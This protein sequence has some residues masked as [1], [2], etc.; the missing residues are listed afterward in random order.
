M[1][2]VKIGD[3]IYKMGMGGLHSSEKTVAHIA[4]EDTLLIDRDV[5]SYYPFI[6]LLLGLYPKHLG[7]HF[8]KVFKIIVDR[9]IA[10]KRAGNK[11]VAD[12]LKITINGTFGKLGDMFS[13]IFSPQLLLQVT[14]SG[15]FYLLMLIEMIDEIGI[16]V[17]S[18]NTD[19]I[20][21][22]CPKSRYDELNAVIAKWE[23]IT[24]FETEETRYS[25]LYS[26]DVNNYI[27]VKDF[28][29]ESEDD[30]SKRAKAKFLDERLGCKPKGA[31]SEK[32][33]ALNSPLSKNPKT[34]VCIDAVM[35]MIVN[36]IPVEETIRTCKDF[37]RFI[38][39]ERARNGAFKGKTY[40]GK[41]VR[42]YYATDQEGGIYSAKSGNIIAKSEGCRVLMDMPKGFFASD[43]D[44][45][46]YIN[47][48]NDM[49]Y[50][51]GFYAKPQANLFD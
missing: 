5:A 28:T 1:I 42:W 2:K 47:E 11:T 24:K 17:V 25:A 9:R 27:A 49:L 26:R 38:S 14:I 13:T 4:T 18:G 48:A 32:G 45:Q 21:I 43:V 44:Y 51:I 16:P 35:Q 50:K 36:R 23:A 41:V 19:G 46:W 20:V 12:S 40:L 7:K 6:I 15:Q 22:K 33:S 8:L 30:K 34:L 10:A 29:S 39:V 3:S 37:R 31:F